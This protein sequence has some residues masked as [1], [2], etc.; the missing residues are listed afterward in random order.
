MRAWFEILRIAL[1]AL[2]R[3]RLR[4]AL[5]TLGILIGVAAVVVVTALGT[6]ARDRIGNE[7]ENI[8]SNLLYVWSRSTA[9]SGVRTATDGLT[10]GDAEAIRREA[11]AV[12]GVTIWSSLNMQVQ[13]EFSNT[14]TSVMGVDDDYFGVRG[15]D[16]GN[17]RRWSPF[18]AQSKAKVVLIGQTVKQNLFGATDP[19]GRF[20]RI[21]RTPFRIIGEL[22][23]RGQSPWEDQDDRLLMPITSFRARVSPGMGRR[24]QLIMA[25]AKTAAHSE[26]ASR[27]IEAILRQRHR[28]EE[29]EESDFTV[30]SQVQFKRRQ[31]EIF[32]LLTTLLLSVAGVSLFVGGVGVMNIMLVSVTER[33]KEIG[34]RMAIG[35]KPRDIQWQF[36]SEAIALTIFGGLSGIGI[37]FGLI[38]LV[39]HL[40]GW[41]MGLSPV[42]IFAAL[43]TSLAVGLIFGFLPAR[44]AARLDPIEALRHE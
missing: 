15:F 38:Q 6:G 10:E 20:V 26:A 44:R 13:S 43:F 7:I 41:S 25:Q 30:R 31:E 17:G 42:A 34:I 36:L 33:T 27:Q 29:G 3:Q 18:E 21:G 37:A 23:P 19:V 16:V 24:V 5:T 2:L 22:K 1:R 35:A 28:I 14:K 39:S 12:S 32:N 11:A 9:S 8:G 40:L 4:S